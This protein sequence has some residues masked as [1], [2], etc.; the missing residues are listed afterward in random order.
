[1]SGYAGNAAAL[2]EQL[3]VLGRTLDQLMLELQDVDAMIIDMRFNQGGHDAAALKIANRFADKQRLAFTK[4]AFS[5]G[6]FTPQQEIFVYPEGEIQF[7]GPVVLLTSPATI[8]AAEIFTLSTMGFPHV[9]RMGER[10]QGIL[11]DILNK[12]LPN[13]WTLGLSNE[14]YTAVDG[15]V[16]EE[17]GIPALVEV[18]VFIP[19]RFYSGLKSQ[20]IRQW[21]CLKSVA[22]LEKSL[23]GCERVP[24]SEACQLRW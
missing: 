8:S 1:M 15:I 21:S 13:G 24:D 22:P 2:P 7:T 16:Y 19:G 4:K 10:T 11:S 14:V 18:P 6:S 20:W 5:N 9:I 23:P 17:I 3:D 12:K